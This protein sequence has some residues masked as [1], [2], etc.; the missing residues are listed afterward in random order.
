MLNMDKLDLLEDVQI[1]FKHLNNQNVE[2]S[3]TL[4]LKDFLKY[5]EKN[6]GSTHHIRVDDYSYD[7][8]TQLSALNIQA[9]SGKNQL[10]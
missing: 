2:I 9:K 3:K 6:S 10:P 1:T 5:M 7:V 8:L 4:N